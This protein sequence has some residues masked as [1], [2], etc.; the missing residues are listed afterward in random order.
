M[1]VKAIE[2]QITQA[3]SESASHKGINIITEEEKR[4]IANVEGNNF[5]A[6]CNSPSEGGEC[7]CVC[8][9][10]QIRGSLMHSVWREIFMG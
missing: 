9:S 3:F 1:W 10:G 7:V 6:D 5:C 8:K 2:L 4:E